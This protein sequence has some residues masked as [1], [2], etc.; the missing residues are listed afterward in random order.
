MTYLK[1]IL[2]EL[3]NVFNSFGKELL[4]NRVVSGEGISVLRRL[5]SHIGF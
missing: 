3:I 4:E 2:Y 5:P 1:I